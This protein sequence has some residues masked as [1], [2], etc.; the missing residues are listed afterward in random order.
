MPFVPRKNIDP[1]TTVG[2]EYPVDLV[3]GDLFPTFMC[4]RIVIRDKETRRQITCESRTFIQ[5]K[6]NAVGAMSRGRK[7]FASQS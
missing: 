4:D 6:C 7:Y 2:G 1:S 5:N 3:L